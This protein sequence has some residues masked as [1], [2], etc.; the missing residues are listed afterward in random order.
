MRRYFFE[1]LSV[2]LLAG[3]L[4]FFWESVSYLSR[5]D[6]IGA[7]VLVL[8]GTSVLSVGKEMARLSLVQKE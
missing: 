6:Y 4:V 5:R 8:I 3:G 1:F 2:A 7:G